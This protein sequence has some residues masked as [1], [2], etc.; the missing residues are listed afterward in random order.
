VYPIDPERETRIPIRGQALLNQAFLRVIHTGD[1]EQVVV[2]ALGPDGEIGDQVYAVTDQLFTIVEGVGEARVGDLVL[3]LEDGDLVFVPA[4]VRFNVI[5][6]AVT[7]LRLIAVCAP[8]L[9]PPGWVERTS[10][11]PIARIA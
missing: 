1:R 4:G 10:R 3:G 11:D 6:R 2:M 9:Y 7:P 8:P 5:N